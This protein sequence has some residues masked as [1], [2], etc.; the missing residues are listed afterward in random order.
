M[1][2]VGAVLL[3]SVGTKW[4][5]IHVADEAKDGMFAVKSSL[6][7]GKKG[8]TA[9]L[10]THSTFSSSFSLSRFVPACTVWKQ[11]RRVTGGGSRGRLS[12]RAY[13]AVG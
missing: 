9:S 1:A 7:L 8:P 6:R 4:Y 5:K 13:L 12:L 3:P 10:A 11:R 2:R